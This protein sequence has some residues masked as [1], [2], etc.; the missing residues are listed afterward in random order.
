MPPVEELEDE[1]E[2]EVPEELSTLL[3]MLPAEELAEEDEDDV[4]RE[5]HA[6]N[7]AVAV[8][9]RTGKTNFFIFSFICYTRL[10]LHDG[11][12]LWCKGRKYFL[13]AKKE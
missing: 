8:N 4:P 1:D 9:S 11:L 5:P 2:E 13:Y 6:V 3:M 12:F 10:E 7:M